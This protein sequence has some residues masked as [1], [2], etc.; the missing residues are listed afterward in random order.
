MPVPGHV[1]SASTSM[2]YESN[3]WLR[4]AMRSF[5]LQAGKLTIPIRV[6]GRGA[7][8]RATDFLLAIAC[9]AVMTTL[10]HT[11]ASPT[12]LLK[13][14][15][16]SK[17]PRSSIDLYRSAVLRLGDVSGSAVP[18]VAVCRK[19]TNARWVSGA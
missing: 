4:F 3:V 1:Q 19:P 2:R 6:I 18:Y 13:L 14:V 17:R 9:L 5:H 10:A 15:K 11:R 16:K 7:M 8:A 12:Q